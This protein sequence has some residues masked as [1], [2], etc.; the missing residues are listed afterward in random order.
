MYKYIYTH[1]YINRNTYTP[2]THRHQL[3]GHGQVAAGVVDLRNGG[4]CQACA[5]RMRRGREGAEEGRERD[6]I[7]FSITVLCY[8]ASHNTLEDLDNQINTHR[9][10]ARI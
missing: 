9:C 4:I 3:V 1:T 10:R 2:D 5:G 7:L 6:Y 8:L